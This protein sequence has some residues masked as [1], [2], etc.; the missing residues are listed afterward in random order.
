MPSEAGR[1][2]GRKIEK[3]RMIERTRKTERGK[4]R[5]RAPRI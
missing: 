5:G 2:E 1:K 4:E 3:D